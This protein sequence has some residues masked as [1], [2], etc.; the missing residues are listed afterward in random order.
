MG[1]AEVKAMA[2]KRIENSKKAFSVCLEG[3][4]YMVKY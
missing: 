3:N 1:S 2:W 4:K